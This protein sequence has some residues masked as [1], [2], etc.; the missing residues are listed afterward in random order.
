MAI[1]YTLKVDSESS[2]E[3]LAQDVSSELGVGIR[4]E[5][6]QLWSFEDSFVFVTIFGPSERGS[7]IVF[8]EY[9]VHPTVCV[10][11]RLDKFELQRAEDVLVTLTL[12]VLR[13]VSGDAILLYN[14]ELPVLRRQ[15]GV[16]SLN[17]GF[18]A[19]SSRMSLFESEIVLGPAFSV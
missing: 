12:A 4:R 1:E 15:A 19:W 2:V 6:T 16:V 17:R 10:G 5:S 18:E 8:E 14:G 11:F 7:R 9:G 3:R 13:S